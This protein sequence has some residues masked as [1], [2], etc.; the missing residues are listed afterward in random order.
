MD[1][2]ARRGYYESVSEDAFF[3][4]ILKA[5]NVNL[6]RYRDFIVKRLNK[7]QYRILDFTVKTKLFVKLRMKK[8]FYFFKRGNNK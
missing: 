8:L 6:G 2:T 4:E 1:K 5:A 7:K 3:K